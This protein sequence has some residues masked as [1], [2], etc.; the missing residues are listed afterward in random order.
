MK[1]IVVLG[2]G[3]ADWKISALGDKTC[4]E[5]A[6]T[7]NLNKLA[8]LSEV[9]LCKTVPDGMKPGSD[10]ANMSVLGFNPYKFYTGRSPLEAVSMGINLADTD[11]TL[12]C[13]LV[14]LSD[15]E[16]YEDR[17]MVDY[18]A[19]EISTEEAAELINYL[20]SHLDS[21][22]FT[23]YSGISYRHCLVV[24]NGV[25]GHELTPPHDISDRK[26]TD[27]LPKGELGGVYLEMM[28][29]SAELLRDH[30]VNVK[31]VADGKK[32]ANSIWLWGEGTKP[33][34]SPFEKERGLKGG[35]ISAV[36]LVKGIGMLADMKIIEV[37]GATG[38]YD[39]DFKGKAEAAA[40]ALIGG[41]DF[42]Y[43]H[44]EAPDE[45][46]HHGDFVH[47]IYSIEQID[48][49]VIPTLID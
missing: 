29:K 5:A 14:T 48:S 43:I 19:G 47:K 45:C 36:D 1:Y 24:K 8:P 3:M 28:K 49:I 32:P 7:V 6:D 42:V 13:N 39:T 20:K 37:D 4:L 2:D 22:K 17:T 27:Y 9:G 23:L 38:N 35:I 40:R 18:S 31:R 41:L 10:V 30:P 11:V 16:N 12:R 21:D 46:G 26:I 15:G 25:T 34:L 33:A 44:M